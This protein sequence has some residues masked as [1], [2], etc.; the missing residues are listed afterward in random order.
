[1]PTMITVVTPCG[2][3][4]IA[5]TA[6][7]LVSYVKGTQIIWMYSVDYMLHVML[8]CILRI[9][10]YSNRILKCTVDHRD[11]TPNASPQMVQ[12]EMEGESKITL[13]VMYDCQLV[14]SK[15]VS[16][17]NVRIML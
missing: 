4:S 5:S 1:M 15:P 2:C 10:F 16:T 6:V 12:A 8:L 11:L 7:L 9:Q 14:T 17:N 13:C 3:K